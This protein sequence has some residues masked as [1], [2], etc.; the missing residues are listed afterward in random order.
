MFFCNSWGRNNN[1]KHPTY[2][3]LHRTKYYLNDTFHSTGSA[4]YPVILSCGSKGT[5]CGVVLS[6]LDN[7]VHAVEHHFEIVNKER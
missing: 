6:H 2:E 3:G 7:Y 1:N 4:V 5:F